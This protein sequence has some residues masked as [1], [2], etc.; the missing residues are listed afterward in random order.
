MKRRAL[1]AG[2]GVGVAATVVGGPLL[3][4]RMTLNEAESM[5]DAPET[6][7]D[8][9]A[10]RTIAFR[11]TGN[12]GLV[13]EP[14]TQTLSAAES[15]TFTLHNRTTDTFGF[16]PYYWRLHKYSDG[17]W[18]RIAPGGVP[19][20]YHFFDPLRTMEW[21]AG[22][23]A[24]E[25]GDWNEPGIEGDS[26]WIGSYLCGSGYY[27]FG[28]EGSF[29]GESVGVV[30]Q[31]KVETGPLSLTV[32]D[33]V[34]GIQWDGETLHATGEYR[35]SSDDGNTDRRRYELERIEDPDDQFERVIEE[36]FATHPPTWDALALA[37]GRDANR[38][39]LEEAVP[40]NSPT[41]SPTEFQF[42]DA[43]Y[44]LTHHR[45]DNGTGGG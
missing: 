13:M 19:M 2:T 33:A 45:L 35:G 44:R 7:P 30:T 12:T 23:Q 31:F 43:Y 29:N 8:Y 10:D 24:P 17:E 38:V 39:E 5:P 25:I 18:F 11:D 36:Q 42:E 27:A 40:T 34:E 4:D 37:V 9:G 20:P 16:N 14:S 21:T 28:T 22:I 6:Y 41:L 32:S 26:R 3:Y 15:V 1:L